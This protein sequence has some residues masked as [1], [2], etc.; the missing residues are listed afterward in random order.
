MTMFTCQGR[1]FE[2]AAIARLVVVDGWTHVP[3]AVDGVGGC[4]WVVEYV[5]EPIYDEETGETWYWDDPELPRRDCG[6]E[7]AYDDHHWVCAAGH[8][9]T[10]AELREA[11]GWDYADGPEEAAMLASVGVDARPI[12]PHTVL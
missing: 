9:H 11:E 7:V 6:A 4:T 12:G 8:E 2:T 3:A 5:P 10:S 1:S